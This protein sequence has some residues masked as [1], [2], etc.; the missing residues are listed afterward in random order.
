M[1][2]S[3]HHFYFSLFIQVK[4]KNDDIYEVVDEDGYMENKNSLKSFIVGGSY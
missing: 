2:L 3:V 4:N 1:L